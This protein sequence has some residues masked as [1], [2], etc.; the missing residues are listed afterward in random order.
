M[1]NNE[2]IPTEKQLD[3]RFILHS[4]GQGFFYTGSIENFHFVYDC[5]TEIGKE[6]GLVLQKEINHY[7]DNINTD[8]DIGLLVISHFDYDHVSG[9]DSLLKNKNIKNVIIPYIPF[10]K[11]IDMAVTNYRANGSGAE[12]WFFNFL[13]QPVKYLESFGNKIGKIYVIQ[14]T[15]GEYD[16]NLFPPD[17]NDPIGFGPKL[18]DELFVFKIVTKN[19][20]DTERLKVSFKR[21]DV[22]YTGI[23][24]EYMYSNNF[25]FVL[26]TMWKFC[27]YYLTPNEKIY[28]G[29]KEKF[30]ELKIRSSEQLI[31]NLKDSVLRKK[32]RNC[33]PDDSKKMN[34]T[35]IV[36]YHTPINTY[37]ASSTFVIQEKTYQ[38][39]KYLSNPLFNTVTRKLNRDFGQLLTGDLDLNTD[40][41]AFFN[42]FKDEITSVACFF[43]AHHGSLHNWN[44]KFL[45]KYSEAAFWLVSA[46]YKNKFGHPHLPVINRLMNLEKNIGWANEFH[47]VIIKGHAVWKQNE[48]NIYRS[49]ITNKLFEEFA[50]IGIQTSNNSKAIIEK[51]EEDDPVNFRS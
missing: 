10:A 7:C 45:E 51:N 18:N 6:S 24:V 42:H 33:Y 37:V 5:G 28:A 44:E 2:S 32:I 35:S 31:I 50:N 43:L 17:Y 29:F 21:R 15:D 12:E 1:I 39:I 30:K 20:N 46:G 13:F 26:H 11:R 47:R 49:C 14:G 34:N 27:F 16:N 38:D 19:L 48:C 41:N 40:S 25:I 23:N 36:L 3:Y 8:E 9:L 4:V 22:G